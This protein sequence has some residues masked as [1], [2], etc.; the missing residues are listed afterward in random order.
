MKWLNR[1]PEFV[2]QYAHARNSQADHFA[3]EILEIADDGSN[4][5][6]T[7]KQGDIEVEVV[8]HDHIARSRLRVDARKWLMSK[9]APKKYGDKVTNELVGADGKDLSLQV[10]FVPTKG[11]KVAPESADDIGVKTAFDVPEVE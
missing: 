4:D 8:N 9:M 7:R 6:M 2:T 11:G 1:Y 3:E 5:Y 10:Q